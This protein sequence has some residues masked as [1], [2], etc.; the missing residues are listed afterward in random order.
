MAADHSPTFLKSAY[1]ALTANRVRVNIP[2][3][4]KSHLARKF[5]LSLRKA[6]PEIGVPEG[7]RTP[8][9]RFRKPVLYPAELPGPRTL[10]LKA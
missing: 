10:T 4:Q 2:I 8:D 7:N 1:R 6:L 5:M 9:P 3:G